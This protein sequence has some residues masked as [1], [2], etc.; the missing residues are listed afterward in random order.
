LLAG[1]SLSA[2]LRPQIPFTVDLLAPCEGGLVLATSLRFI[3][4]IIGFLV[5]LLSTRILKGFALFANIGAEIPI[6]ILLLASL[7]PVVSLSRL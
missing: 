6:S 4:R 5:L 7:R 2:F 1:E 3:D